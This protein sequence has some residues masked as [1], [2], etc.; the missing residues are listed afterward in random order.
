MNNH[1]LEYKLERVIL[2]YIL[3]MIDLNSNIVLLG[4]LVVAVLGKANSVAIAACL[5]LIIKLLK[6]DEFVYPL[7][8]KNGV[9]LGL[10]I[11]IAAILIP[12]ASGEIT[13]SNVKGIFTSWIGIVALLLSFFTTYLSGQGLSYL[14]VQGH[15]DIIPAIIFGSVLAAVFLGGVPVGPLITSGILALFVRLSNKL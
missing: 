6:F 5:L 14:T 1:F 13:L 12:I 2:K 9:N 3:E 4:I 15:S 10:I 8:E 11:L 7:I